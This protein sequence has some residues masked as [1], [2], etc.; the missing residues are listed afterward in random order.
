MV[1]VEDPEGKYAPGIYQFSSQKA[2]VMSELPKRRLR[3]LVDG[4]GSN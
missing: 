2:L 1:W 3:Q 4:L